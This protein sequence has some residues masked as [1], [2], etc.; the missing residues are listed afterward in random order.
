M[1]FEEFCETTGLHG[2]KYIGTVSVK[3]I[4]IHKIK[5]FLVSFV[6]PYLL[7]NLIPKKLVFI[8]LLFYVDIFK[9]LFCCSFV[10][11]S[12]IFGFLLLLVHLVLQYSS[13]TWQWLTSPAAR[14]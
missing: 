8:A 2:W 11:K 5:P 6:F 4:W 14:W 12:A 13:S 10:Q 1:Q 7:V 3:E 9:K